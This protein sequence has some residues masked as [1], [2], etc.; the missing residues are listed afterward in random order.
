M[1][2]AARAKAVP[3][4]GPGGHRAIKKNSVDGEHLTDQLKVYIRAVGAKRAFQFS[5]YSSMWQN[6]AVRPEALASSKE[7]LDALLKVGDIIS[8]SYTI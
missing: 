7:F 4:R 2:A 3:A 1:P 8:C 5:E 6:C